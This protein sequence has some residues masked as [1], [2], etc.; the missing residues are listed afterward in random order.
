MLDGVGLA[1]QE[2]MAGAVGD[3]P[4]SF[5]VKIRIADLGHFLNEPEHRAELTGTVTCAALGGTMPV[6]D[7]GFQLFVVDAQSGL[8]QL[9]YFFRFTAAG[10]DTY[11]LYGHKDVHDDPGL[12]VVKDMTCLYTNVYRGEDERAPLYASGELRFGMADLPSL[13]ASFK[14]ENAGDWTQELAARVAFASFAWGQLRDE[15]LGK[16]RLFYDTRYENLAAAG[17]LQSPGGAAPFFLVSGVHDKG[18]PWGDGELFWDVLLAVG[19][20]RGGYRRFAI[21]DRVLAGLHLDIGG[22]AYWYSGPLFELGAGGAISFSE[23]KKGAPGLKKVQAEI[24][25]QFLAAAYEA[26]SFPFTLVEPAV[27]RLSSQI[28]KELREALPGENAPGIFITPH[29]AAIRGGSIQV[30]GEKWEIDAAGSTGECERGT[31][32]NLKEPTL[33]YGYLCALRPEQR[34][35]RVQIQSRTFRNDKEFW[36]K[37]RVDA[38]LGAAIERMASVE[39]RMQDGAFAVSPLPPAGKP[40]ERAVPLQKIG[41]PI[42]EVNNDHFPTAVFQRRIVEVQDASG[43]R[44]LALEEDMRA[45]RLE[46]IGCDRKTTVAAM[47]GED[48]LRTLDAVLEAT[49]FDDAVEEKARASSKDKALFS[50][51]IKPNFM[52]AY[53]KRDVSTYTDPELVAHLARRLRARGFGTIRVVEAQSTYG[54][55]FDKRSVKEMAE[56]LGYDGAAGYEIVDMTLDADEQRNLGPHLGMHPVSRVWREADFR[57]SFAKNKTHAYSYY[58]LTLKNI[59]GA[60]PLANKFLEYHCRRD[61]YH[62]TME[63]LAAFP[64]HFGLV[65]GWRSADGPFGVFASPAPNET[66]T[67]IGGADLVA[68]DWVGASKMG[69]DPMLSKH[70][71]LAVGLFGK[72]EIELIGDANPYR[73]WLNVPAVLTAAAHEGMDAEYRFGNLLYSVAAQMDETHFRHT[74]D[75]WYIKVLREM[76]VPLRRTFFLRTG[77][78]PTAANRFFSKLFYHL[79]Y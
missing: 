3:R 59:Y 6:R 2:A 34:S 55:Y 8:R 50:I 1:F 26:V 75:E 78:E 11:Y 16:V 79:G 41:A 25:I 69:I 38:A 58:T 7:G 40:E 13:L 48:K 44:S 57:I 63:Y 46:A 24:S 53:D 72:P 28:Q 64:V 65:D 62:T 42:V 36:I 5:D 56:Y 30:D 54:Q 19:D 66:H 45:L 15:Y 31:F 77:E 4:L 17:R 51:A 23:I 60:L 14:V 18:F 29:L 9:R 49:R 61:I 37:D 20:G 35:A 74:S 33:L 22:G 43:A 10:G 76:T 21:T 73:P 12:D 68:V 32:R 70:M 47:R 71:E 52:F 67:I 39:F 27:R